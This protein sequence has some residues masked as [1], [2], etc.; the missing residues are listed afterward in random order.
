MCSWTS[1]LTPFDV[2]FFFPMVCLSQV[3]LTV[4]L[5]SLYLSTDSAEVRLFPPGWSGTGPDIALAAEGGCYGTSPP[6]KGDQLSI[7]GAGDDRVEQVGKEY[8]EVWE[9]L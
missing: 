9:W 2:F 1:S 8:Q 5:E 6:S 7:S 3:K 4:N